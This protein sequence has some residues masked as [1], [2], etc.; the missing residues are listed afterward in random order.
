MPLRATVVA[1]DLAQLSAGPTIGV[2]RNDT[3]G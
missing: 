2:G 1:G 3:G